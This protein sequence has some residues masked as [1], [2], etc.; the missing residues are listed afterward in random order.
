MLRYIDIHRVSFLL[1]YHSLFDKMHNS[2]ELL[3]E[4]KEI[5]KEIK[6]QM[7]F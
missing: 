5:I 3:Q 2:E 4:V 1:E 7:T 6:K